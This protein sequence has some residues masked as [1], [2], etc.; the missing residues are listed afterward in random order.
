MLVCFGAFI[1]CGMLTFICYI[2]VHFTFGLLDYTLYN[3]D[4]V[5]SRFCSI[6]FTVTLAGLKNIKHL[7]YG[8]E[9]NSFFFP[10]VLMF[11]ETK[12]RET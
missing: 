7:M 3:E 12:S 9:G 6:D 10:R 11:P 2:K 5:M 4:F 8:A 1:F